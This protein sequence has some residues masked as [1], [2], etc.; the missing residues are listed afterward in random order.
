MTYTY[1]V[2]S[3]QYTGEQF[4]VEHPISQPA[5]TEYSYKG[6]V[7]KVKRIIAGGTRFI[8]KGG[9]WARDGYSQGVQSM[10]SKEDRA[11]FDKK[12]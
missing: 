3:G 5:F 12:P 6:R 8:L 2:C 9:N 1:E 11:N 7:R 4:E 10:P